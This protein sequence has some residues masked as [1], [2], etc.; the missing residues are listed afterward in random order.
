MVFPM[1]Y[2]KHFSTQHETG[3][4]DGHTPSYQFRLRRL[5]SETFL[6]TR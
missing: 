5:G 2:L 1:F 3:Y 4:I 6:Y